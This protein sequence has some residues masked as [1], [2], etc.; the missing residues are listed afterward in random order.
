MT[1]ALTAAAITL[2]VSCA[3]PR[4]TAAEW[5]LK[6]FVGATYGGDT[7]FVLM[8][9]SN[10]A[11]FNLGVNGTWLG[12]VFGLEAD[13]GNTSGFFDDVSTG[14]PLVATSGVTTLTGNVVVAMPRKLAEYTLRPYVV[15]GAGLMHVRLELTGLPPSSSTLHAMDLGAGVT[16]FLTRRVGVSWDVRYFR[17]IDRTPQQNG[18]TFSIEPLKFWRASMAL[19][20]RL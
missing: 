18:S 1:R 7:T 10:K 8:P 4:A 17:T 14:V 6:P 20:T 2:I 15:G 9:G 13:L 19:A 3:A 11:H 12:E 5:Q 16:G